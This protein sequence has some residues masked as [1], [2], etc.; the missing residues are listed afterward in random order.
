MGR[1]ADY[2]RQR[3]ATAACL[4]IIGEPWTMLIIRDAFR[5]LTRFEQWQEALG[6]ARNVLA[7]RLKHLVAEGIFEQ[8]VYCLRP[9]RHEYVL[10]P[11]G[12]DLRGILMHM[13]DWGAKHVYR[14]ETPLV[15]VFHSRCGCVLS[16]VT[17]CAECSEPVQRGEVFIQR[18]PE[19]KSIAELARLAMETAAE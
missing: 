18:N 12:Y 16:P 9:L 7:S 4:D 3:D 2:S 5:G 10:T 17:Y 13:M 8:R 14:D 11:K 15:Q 1:S 19:A 6:L